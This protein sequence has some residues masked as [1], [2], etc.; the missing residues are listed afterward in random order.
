[1]LIL[2]ERNAM[3]LKYMIYVPVLEIELHNNN[4][5]PVCRCLMPQTRPLSVDS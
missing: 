1:M 4:I 2:F 5:T 3:F